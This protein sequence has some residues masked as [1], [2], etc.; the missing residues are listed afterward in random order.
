M[1]ID[2]RLADRD[3]RS[4]TIEP[5]LQR[6]LKRPRECGAGKPGVERCHDGQ[7]ELPGRE[8]AQ[9]AQRGRE[10]S[11]DVHQVDLFAAEELPEL[12]LQTQPVVTRAKEP[13]L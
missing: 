9:Q 10:A 11:V 2:H 8:R 5:L 12:P 4:V 7:V 6:A 13:L 3:G 1:R